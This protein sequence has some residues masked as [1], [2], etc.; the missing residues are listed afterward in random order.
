MI[1]RVRARLLGLAF[2]IAGALA[3]Q[4]ATSQPDLWLIAGYGTPVITDSPFNAGGELEI[5]LG[6][7]IAQSDLTLVGGLANS[8]TS[9]TDNPERFSLFVGPGYV[10]TDRVIFFSLHTGVSYPFYR[11]APEVVQNVS[12]YNALDLGVRIVPKFALG[13]GFN[14]YISREVPA[15]HLR[16]MAIISIL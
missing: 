3:A 5:K 10:F 7:R 8:L 2:F 1:H 14:S 6:G 9:G 12:W 13:I 16:F 15:Y 4:D 11:N